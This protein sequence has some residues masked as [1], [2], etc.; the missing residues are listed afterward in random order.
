M[1]ALPVGDEFFMKYLYTALIFMILS[2]CAGTA[3]S[4]KVQSVYDDA[5]IVKWSADFRSGKR[6]AVLAE[7]EKDLSSGKPH[8]A[9]AQI[10]CF[11][12]DESDEL[13]KRWNDLSNEK[14]RRALGEMPEIYLLYRAGEYRK[15]LEKYPAAK[16][17]SVKNLYALNLLIKAASAETDWQTELVYAKAAVDLNGNDFS[18]VW[19]ISNDLKENAAARAELEKLVGGKWQGILA[20]GF[21]KK[22]LDAPD[23]GI[24]DESFLPA[25]DE[26]LGK[27][28]ND[29]FMLYLKGIVLQNAGRYAE[30]AEIYRQSFEVFPFVTDG[31]VRRYL[32]TLIR[33]N[34]TD[35]AKV[36][37]KN[38]ALQADEGA[39]AK[40]YEIFLLTRAFQN[41][42]SKSEGLK[43]INE[44]ETEISLD[45]RLLI[46]KARLTEDFENALDLVSEAIK[47]EPENRFWHEEF[48][49]ITSN[50]NGEQIGYE[51][52]LEY[53]RKFAQ[54]SVD[55]FYNASRMLQ[56]LGRQDERIKLCQIALEIFRGSAMM[57]RELAE[58][59]IKTGQNAPALESL[60]KSF[61]LQGLNDWSL[62][63][64]FDLIE[65]SRIFAELENFKRKYPWIEKTRNYA[66][67]TRKRNVAEQPSVNTAQIITQLG[68]SGAVN[69]IALSA[70]AKFA[71]TAGSDGFV[72]LWQTE[73]GLELNGFAHRGKVNVVRFSP[74]GLQFASGGDDGKVYIRET[75][76]GKV[77]LEKDVDFR[78]NALDFSPDGKFL[79]FGSSD[80]KAS[81]LDVKTGEAVKKFITQS[82]ANFVGFSS[83]GNLV[84]TSAEN[85]TILW[86]AQTQFLKQDYIC[87][88]DSD[89]AIAVDISD[90]NKFVLSVCDKSSVLLFDAGTG[91][92]IAAFG[93]RGQIA[94]ASFLPDGK[95][96][97]T[98]Q[99]N[100]EIKIFDIFS[101]KEIASFKSFTSGVK[102]ANVSADGKIFALA[103]GGGKGFTGNVETGENRMI[104]SG[105][106]SN[107]TAVLR[108][109]NLAI[110]GNKNS[111][112]QVW[113]L[114]TGSQI[115][116]LAGHEQAV[117][118]LVFSEK[119]NVLASGSDDGTIRFWNL[120][121]R[122]QI[123]NALQHEGK[124]KEIE[125][126]ADGKFL[127]AID[128]LSN[129]SLWNVAAQ[130]KIGQYG[131]NERISN[132]AAFSADSKS[133]LTIA[134]D[135]SAR[136]YD[137]ENGQIKDEKNGFG[138]NV[139]VVAHS[140]NENVFVAGSADG[141][142]TVW[143]GGAIVFSK[144]FEGG[145]T[146]A[147]FSADGKTL[148]ATS[149][150]NRAVFINFAEGNSVRE[151]GA[152]SVGNDFA[153]VSPDAD[154]F[155][156]ANDNSLFLWN[157]T[158]EM[159]ETFAK[160]PE[161]N[162][163]IAFSADGKRLLLGGNDSSTKIIFLRDFDEAKTN[164][165][166]G[167]EICR[168]IS[169]A[170]KTWAVVD[171]ARRYDASNE[172]L[173]GGLHYAV[174]TETVSLEQLKN[175]YYEPELLAKGLGYNKQPLKDVEKWDGV[176]LNPQVTTESLDAD[177]LKLKITLK[178]RG[179]GIGRVQIFLNDMEVIADARNDEQRR[180]TKPEKPIEIP[181]D[182]S[183]KKRYLSNA[184]DKDGKKFENSVR[185]V[186]WNDEDWLSSRSG[187][188]S[189]NSDAQLKPPR[190]YAIIGGVSDY[191]GSEIDLTFAGKDANDFAQ[192]I[193]NGARRMLCVGIPIDSPECNE[194]INITL[195]TDFKSDYATRKNAQKP[196]KGN[197]KKAF[198]AAREAAA[199]DIF[200]V[201]LSGHGITLENKSDVYAYLAADAF[202]GNPNAFKDEDLLNRQAITSVE[203]TDWIKQVP[204]LKRVMILDTCA[205]GGAAEKLK[206]VEQKNLSGDQIRAI[207]RLK[208][209]TGFYVLMGSAADAVSYEAST[210]GQ[211]LLTY[212]LLFGISTGDALNKIDGEANIGEL[213]VYAT[214]KV[215]DLARN[216]GGIQKPKVITPVNSQPFPIGIFTSS[217]R[218]MIRL[219]TSKPMFLRPRLTNLDPNILDDNLFL[220]KAV[221]NFLV[222]DIF[223]KSRNG[224]EVEV[225]FLNSDDDPNSYRIVGAYTIAGE[226]ISV[227]IRLRKDNATLPKETVVE[228]TAEDKTELAKK[229]VEAAKKL[230]NEGN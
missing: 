40:K 62:T 72:R 47:I 16:V 15:I 138:T 196:T 190:L 219:P 91:V 7:V 63:A 198:E 88:N 92:K 19:D 71:A 30:A 6:S 213:F 118:R 171:S 174:G 218:S 81:V 23:E 127:Y 116:V 197:F 149:A 107:V 39:E 29:R 184:V 214:G 151:L 201:Y 145:I 211:G 14:L 121:E 83:T 84:L 191:E 156:T 133:F 123:G 106:V 148:L 153:A 77:L 204:A 45:A 192:A 185:I 1:L 132:V 58:A 119:T 193:E 120:D 82:A 2:V 154:F 222:N 17:S 195:L 93:E 74:D 75:A 203:L 61:E 134:P 94:A 199:D 189:V 172:G 34:K 226:K 113:D 180:N 52:F 182:L 188:Y 20:G 200:I 206:F 112:I 105:E 13:T 53:E 194:R 166:A 230:I 33:L 224:Q 54:K 36:F 98:V 26:W 11:L 179:G 216:I 37:A 18:A 155:V 100:G 79:L 220:E 21:L 27:H 186:A 64:Y 66:G 209:T 46:Q 164:F 159:I 4:Q 25:I 70:D 49:E 69:S 110:T 158:G 8:P 141:T 168:F 183:D 181:V 150:E 136:F 80:T 143:N 99:K 144:K 60:V 178:N 76:T 165:K 152:R 65:K 31:L 12:L 215:P 32:E 97:F 229:I 109:K 140:P 122:R 78:I 124:I 10:W 130:N 221:S 68:H 177:G 147:A 170:D 35:E 24:G 3:F 102:T 227:K 108:A 205:A 55:A 175:R 223:T 139:S 212:S 50:K 104:L 73:T 142:F 225:L 162:P 96:I 28:E 207:A 90:D 43:L 128:N 126:S 95:R 5:R 176:K 51:K 117:T 163:V 44:A 56:K 22:V 9:A 208:D 161:V 137:A 41:T 38:Y 103:D 187:V 101:A 48:I 67:G 131:A 111:E 160:T 228:G 210:Y 89:V 217:E 85:Q 57:Y 173:V 115:G 114:K 87:T 129:L 135:G 125:F 146:S 169:F 157:K 59:Q 42:N 86:D 167:D 202:T